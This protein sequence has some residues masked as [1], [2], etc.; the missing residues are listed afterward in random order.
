MQRVRVFVALLL[1][2]TVAGCVMFRPEL[3]SKQEYLVALEWYNDNLEQY[4]EAY[5]AAPPATQAEW[6]TKIKP[7]FLHANEVLDE[8]YTG[9]TTGIDWA[10]IQR[11]ILTALITHAVIIKED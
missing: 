10:S 2:F 9:V 5:R 6:D 3:T 7:L 8:W 1:V 4:L 11:R